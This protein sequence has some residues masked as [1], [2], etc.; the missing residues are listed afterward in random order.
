[1]HKRAIPAGISDP[2]TSVDAVH[3]DEEVMEV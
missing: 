3:S 2:S 1:M